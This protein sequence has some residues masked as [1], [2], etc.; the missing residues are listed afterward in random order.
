MH[1]GGESALRAKRNKPAAT[2]IFILSLPTL[3]STLCSLH[4]HHPLC[5][6]FSVVCSWCS[7]LLLCLH[8]CLCSCC[9]GWGGSSSGLCCLWSS[10]SGLGCLWNSSSSSSSSSSS[11]GS[12]CCSS[13][14]SSLRG[15]CGRGGLAPATSRLASNMHALLDVVILAAQGENLGKAAA[16]VCA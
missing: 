7:L 15:S 3:F 5:H 13:G 11:G 10:S 16:G 12:S 14:H 9:L 6:L 1:S 8:L 4:S 2:C